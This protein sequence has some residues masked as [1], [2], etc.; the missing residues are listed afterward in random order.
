MV[1]RVEVTEKFNPDSVV[2]KLIFKPQD[3]ITMYAR[4]IDLDYATR[5]GF[6]TDTSISKYNGVVGEKELE[7]WDAPP[8]TMNGDDLKLDGTTVSTQYL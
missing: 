7:P 1:H 2:E 5:D 8:A 6:R 3:I 4:D